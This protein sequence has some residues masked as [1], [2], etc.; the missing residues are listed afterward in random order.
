[1]LF[2]W[3]ALLLGVWSGVDYHVRILRHVR[4]D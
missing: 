3:V 4:L 2:L 1:M